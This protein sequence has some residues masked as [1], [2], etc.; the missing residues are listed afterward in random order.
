VVQEA[1]DR[2]KLCEERESVARSR[3]LDDWKFANA[4]AYNGFQW[5]NDLRRTREIDD[6]P[7]LTLNGVRQHNLQ[8]TNDAKQNKPGMK[9]MP[10]GGGATTES[11]GAISALFRHIEYISDATVAYD[12]ASQF[13]V[14]AGWGYL[15]V[16]T[17]YL[18]EDTF[19][20]DIIIRAVKNPLMVYLDHDGIDGD[21]RDPRFG[22][23]FEDIPRDEF[24]KDPQYS[25]E[26]KRL[27][28]SPPFA[29]AAGWISNDFVRIADYY[30]IVEENDVL[31]ALP[32]GFG[33]ES[34]PGGIIRRSMLT[35]SSKKMPAPVKRAL[36][37]ALE[38]DDR[39]RS[40]DVVTRR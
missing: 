39:V 26:T 2:F 35:S 9:A 5:P 21:S 23:I 6:R 11:A 37:D 38:K 32:K 22:I 36:L 13:Q 34:F 33:H 31:Y 40:R 18:D 17:A 20:Q 8:I 27:A 1:Y 29:D 30:R 28:T 15:R 4:D 25:E 12:L 10:T 16:T 7:S 19:D 14:N 3:F 24:E